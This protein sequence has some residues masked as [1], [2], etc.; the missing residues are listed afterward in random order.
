VFF[1]VDVTTERLNQIAERFDRR[2]LVPRVG[3]VVPLEQTRAAHEMLAGAPHLPG[4]IV[5]SIG[6]KP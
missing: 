6:D 2:Q 3:T 4:K 1:F 5:L